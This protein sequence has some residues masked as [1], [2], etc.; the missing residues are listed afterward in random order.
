MPRA[1]KQLDDGE[2]DV[3]MRVKMTVFET[4]ALEIDDILGSTQTIGEE[5][6]KS[7]IPKN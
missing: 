1:N 4:L 7:N 5:K 6:S 2:H 3:R